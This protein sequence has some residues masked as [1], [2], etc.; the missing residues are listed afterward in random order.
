M[1]QLGLFSPQHLRMALHWLL[2]AR[3][4]RLCHNPSPY[5]HGHTHWPLTVGRNVCKGSA[6]KRIALPVIAALAFFSAV[7][8]AHAADVSRLDMNAAPA[9][10]QDQVRR[11]QQALQKKGFTPGPID[12]LLGPHTKSAIRQ[13]QDRYA[14][15]GNGDINNQTLFALGEPDL[16][17]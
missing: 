5:G 13:F 8:G 12:G 10:N 2:P 11:V 3:T 14:I 9:L 16:A 7:S 4:I 6:M 1:M 17:S 15:Q